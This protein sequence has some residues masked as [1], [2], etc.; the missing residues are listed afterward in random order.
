MITII[1]LNFFSVGSPI[2]VPKTNC[3]TEEIINK[4]H[5]QFTTALVTLF[6]ENKHKFEEHPESA[7]LIIE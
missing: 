5:E 6:E 2:Y 1:I 4:F 7:K 3:P